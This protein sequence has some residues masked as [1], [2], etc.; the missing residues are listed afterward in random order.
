MVLLRL[1]WSHNTSTSVLM[2]L[3]DT[4]RHQLSTC[5]WCLILCPAPTLRAISQSKS[6]PL[7]PRLS[8]CLCGQRQRFGDIWSSCS[9]R[10]S[11]CPSN[12]GNPLTSASQ[13]CCGR[14]SVCIFL[15][16]RSCVHVPE[17]DGVF[18]EGGYSTAGPTNPSTD[19]SPEG[20][21]QEKLNKHNHGLFLRTLLL[22]DPQGS[23]VFSLVPL[24]SSLEGGFG[25][26]A[27]ELWPFWDSRKLSKGTRRE[28]T[29][30]S[31]MS[32]FGSLF[33][34]HFCPLR[35]LQIFWPL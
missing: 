10:T 30:L 6:S 18:Q 7:P 17:S 21:T 4:H 1:G 28:A 31:G 11:S 26:L 12:T 27:S 22:A 19:R 16:H 9:V 15:R 20:H 2:C 32:W 5:S 3:Y 24:C 8:V 23:P 14:M 33:L 25:G 29:F 34:L 35:G 13:L